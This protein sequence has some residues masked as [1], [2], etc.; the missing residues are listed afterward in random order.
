MVGASG[1]GFS[2]LGDVWLTRWHADAARDRDGLRLWIRDRAEGG[3]WLADPGF[4]APGRVSERAPFDPGVVTIHAAHREIE[5]TLEICVAPQD[6]CELRRLTLRNRS[7]RTRTLEITTF[8]E[9]ALLPLEADL[10]HPAFSR[11]FVQTE[12]HAPSA[13][14]LAARRPRRPTEAW[15]VV[16]HALIGEGVVEFESDRARFIGR[17]R[18]FDAPMALETLA[19]LSGTVGGVLDPALSQRRMVELV[20]GASVELVAMM[21]AAPDRE[22]ALQMVARAADPVQRAAAFEGARDQARERLAALDL[23]AAEAADLEALASALLCGAVA[24]HERVVAGADAR[25]RVRELGLNPDRVRVVADVR[26]SEAAGES[27]RLA[28]A[29]RYWDALGVSIDACELATTR[30]REAGEESQDAPGLRLLAAS[31][32]A[33]EDVEAVLASATLVV[34]GGGWPTV[35]TFGDVVNAAP[36]VRARATIEREPATSSL[37]DEPLRHFNGIGGW[38][39][40]GDE[41]VIRAARDENGHLRLPPRPWTNVIANPRFG[42]LISE[43]GASCTWSANSRERRLTPW[44]NDPLLDP[45]H[46]TL[47][48]RD[49]E[50]GAFWSVFPGPRPAAGNFEI[51]HGF[52]YTVCRHESH[53]IEHEAFAFVPSDDP[54]KLVRITLRNRGTRARRVSVFGYQRLVLG[55]LPSRSSRHVETWQEPESGAVMARQPMS[56]E[57]AP[58]VAFAAIVVDGAQAE[59]CYSGDRANFLGPEGS[60]EAPAALRRPRLEARFGAGLDACFAEQALLTIAPGASAQVVVMLGEGADL[61]ESRRLLVRY[62]AVGA[63][64]RALEEVREFW[65]DLLGA[66]RIETPEPALDLMAN[67][68]LLYQTVSCRMWGRTAFDQSGGA[69]GFR[70]QLQDAASLVSVR[71]DWTRAQILLH[72][73]H[74]FVEGDVLHWWHPPADRGLRTRFADDLLWLPYVTA[75]YVRSSGDAKILGEMVPY[76]RAAALDPGHDEA[77]VTPVPAQQ[78]RDLYEHCCHAIDRSMATGVHGLPLFGTGDWNDGM[79]AVGREGRGE[80]VWMGFFLHAVLG[81]FLP[82][83][84]AR[85]DAPRAERYEEHRERLRAALEHEGWDGE[86]YRRGWYDDGAP[87]GSA[88]SD[89]C[90]IDALA[91]AWS[92]LSHAVP[93]DRAEQAIAA[94]EKWLVSE[95]EGLI[96]LLT[97]PF[98]RTPHDPGYIKGYVPGVRENGGQYTH[99]AIW[100]VRALCELG[101]SERAAQLMRMLSPVT[102]ASTPAEVALYQAEPYVVAADVYGAAPHVGRGGWTWYTGSAGWMYRTIIESLLGVRIEGREL[103][104]EPRMPASWGRAKIDYR[105]PGALGRIEIR[106]SV[107]GGTAKGIRQATFDGAPLACSAGQ[108]RVRIP[109]GA[110]RHEL[111]VVLE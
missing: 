12:M 85:G 46:E 102:H 37:F 108:L 77:L 74:Q 89:E 38:N 72:A 75:A 16:V 67:G 66:V 39:A 35:T 76:L 61:E 7:D 29:Q 96:R 53:G 92:V 49:E 19:S 73:A 98:D 9:I 28:R 90:R 91:Q 101:Q 34:A 79:N 8:C 15:P 43:T 97:P 51:R 25:S 54:I 5:S 106:I 48:V 93:R 50:S 71:P 6:D 104:V 84:R 24:P 18:D 105:P 103:I 45:H 83:C 95:G 52:G 4:G 81:D 10:S 41:Y 62:R 11:L 65:R 99:A 23:D 88:S 40:A 2:A 30:S 36:P 111:V 59:V 60:I 3:H 55:E 27:A 20:P 109:E 107:S 87:L 57:F 14:L 21:G 100:V 69:F 58:R 94:V 17:G 56:G 78:Y 13:A 31:S 80:S 32:L 70:D 68:W 44:T 42:F 110:A 22:A 33:N 82:L 47:F 63:A 26:R 64:T 1:G 86:W